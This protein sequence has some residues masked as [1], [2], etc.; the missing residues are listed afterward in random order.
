MASPLAEAGGVEPKDS[1]EDMAA[2]VEEGPAPRPAI[3]HAAPG[4]GR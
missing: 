2:A 4:S 1:L 3:E